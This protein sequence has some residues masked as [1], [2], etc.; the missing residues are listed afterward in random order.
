MM[1]KEKVIGRCILVEIRE[2]DYAQKYEYENGD[3]EWLSGWNRA[4]NV[5]VGDKGLMV[6]RSTPS[7]GLSFFVKDKMRI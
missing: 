4:S 1:E 5:K 7:W 3:V 2:G 6:Y